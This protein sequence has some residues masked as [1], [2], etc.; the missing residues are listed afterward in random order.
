MTRKI[1][2]FIFIGLIFTLAVWMSDKN[3]VIT[4]DWRGYVN[5]FSIPEAMLLVLVFVAVV[6]FLNRILRKLVMAQVK[7]TYRYNLGNTVNEGEAINVLAD[8]ISEKIVINRHDFDNSLLLVL[9][10]MT[11]IT[12][13]DMKEARMNLR[14]LKKLIGN[15]PIIDLL[16][17]KIYKGEKDFDKMEKLSAK[18]NFV[19]I[20]TGSLR[21][22]LNFAPKPE[23]GTA[24]CRCS[25]R[26]LRKKLFRR[27]SL[28]A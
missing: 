14:A 9:R 2:S 21:A 22:L 25:L 8:K 1:S 24:L 13:G 4:V 5:R 16:K 27:T 23:I 3:S 28:S 10:T 15:D 18:I 7:E 6:D 17:M 11:S 19:R 12:A 20:C 26:G